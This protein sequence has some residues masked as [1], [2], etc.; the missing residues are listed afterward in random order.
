MAASGMRPV[1]AGDPWV[2]GLSGLQLAIPGVSHLLAA[3]PF[4]T[5]A[6]VMVTES[7]QSCYQLTLCGKQA[8]LF[9]LSLLLVPV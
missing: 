1:P 6:T 9:A 3:V 8:S 5:A 7:C 4:G 2:V